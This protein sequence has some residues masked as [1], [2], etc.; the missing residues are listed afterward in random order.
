MRPRPGDKKYRILITG[1]ELEELKRFTWSMAEAFGLNR[2]IEKYKGTR[3]IGLYRWDLDCLDGV[4]SLAL[5]DQEEYPDKAGPGYEAMKRLHG[6]IKRLR[7]KA[8][9]KLR[10]R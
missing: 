2:R 10:E 6:R 1:R 8:Y 7:A 3:P 4:T 9:A 5:D